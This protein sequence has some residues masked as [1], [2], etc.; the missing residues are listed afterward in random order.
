[1]VSDLRSKN[2]DVR[3]E[4]GLSYFIYGNAQFYLKFAIDVG[5]Y[6]RMQAHI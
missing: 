6:V 5:L 3:V 1:M 2:R 4:D